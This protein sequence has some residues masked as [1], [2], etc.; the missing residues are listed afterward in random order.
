MTLT[1]QKLD[2]L[3]SNIQ[4]VDA[5][6]YPTTAFVF[7]LLKMFKKALVDNQ[8]MS[9]LL[10]EIDAIELG[11][12]LQSGGTYSPDLTS[13]YLSTASSLFVAD[14]LLDMALNYLQIETNAI[15]S[16]AGLNSDGTYS[17]DALS[18]YI[19]TALSLKS[20]DSLIDA[21]LFSTQSEL[22]TAES[23]AGLNTDG[24]YTA[25]A[26]TNYLTTATSLKDA[27]KKLDTQ[28]YA[29][30]QRMVSITTNYTALIGNY[31]L[32][33][34]ATA[35]AITVTLPL[36][37]TA[38]TFIIGITKTDATANAVSI[39]PS[40]TDLIC[41]STSQSLLFQNEVYN[42]ISDGTN[43]QLAN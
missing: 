36:A 21:Q 43:W 40:G 38:T 32:L 39:V 7:Y 34:D 30:A 1:I 42:F 16:G 19:S 9:A 10:A 5:N 28:I 15:E 20:A 41:G 27:D 8:N 23:G 37:S 3:P 18:H 35:G 17:A 4:V 11:A 14:I 6:G 22:N 33:A 26:T 12:G 2:Q 31:S 25:D 13:H 29:T 24:T